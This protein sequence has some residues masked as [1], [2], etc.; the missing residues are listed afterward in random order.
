VRS[1]VVVNEGPTKSHP[2]IAR[3]ARKRTGIVACNVND[4]P[5]ARKKEKK[6]EERERRRASC[7]S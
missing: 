7:P 1:R 4:E 6:A 2:W 5:R 3:E